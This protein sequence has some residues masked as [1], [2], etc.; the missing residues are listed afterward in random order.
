MALDLGLGEARC[1]SVHGL[2]HVASE[3][4]TQKTSLF[5]NSNGNNFELFIGHINIGSF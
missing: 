1:W 3:N 4:K 5:T 2:A